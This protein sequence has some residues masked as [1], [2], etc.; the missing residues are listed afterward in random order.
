MKITSAEIFLFVLINQKIKV[1]CEPDFRKNL[2][3]LNTYS[4]INMFRYICVFWIDSTLIHSDHQRWAYFFASYISDS[5]CLLRNLSASLIEIKLLSCLALS[6]AHTLQSLRANIWAAD[7]AAA[8][9]FTT[10]EQPKPKE[11]KRMN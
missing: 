10:V 11:W 2:F 3:E 5:R 7:K 9:A 4:V 6:L 8:S 1:H